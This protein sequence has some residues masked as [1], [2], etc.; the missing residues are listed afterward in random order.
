M[1][2]HPGQLDFFLEPLFPVRQRATT[3][4]IERFRGKL[5]RAMSQAV[6]ECPYGREVIAARMAQYL[7]L[8][9]LS[10]TTLDA[11]TAESKTTHDISLVRFKAFVRATNALWLWDL[12]VSEDGLTMLE[13]DE[14]R[15]AEIARLQQEQRALAQE[16]KSLR[17]IPINIK[18]RGR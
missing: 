1:S 10:K 7:G 11:Y 9:N 13:G 17:S 12:I 18:R 14:A 8:P 2:K 15:L 16:L 3:I 4:D 6:R 5:K